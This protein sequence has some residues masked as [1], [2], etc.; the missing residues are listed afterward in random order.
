VQI[1][2]RREI[3]IG[4]QIPRALEIELR[5]QIIMIVARQI[6]GPRSG[7][8]VLANPIRV[9][10]LDSPSLSA[11][12]CGHLRPWSDLVQRAISSVAGLAD[13]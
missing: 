10:Q 12:S 13:G 5:R 3:G 6:F 1:G 7:I 2:R 4:G 8:R 9:V 11:N